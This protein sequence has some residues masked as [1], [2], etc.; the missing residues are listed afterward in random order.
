M[1]QHGRKQIEKTRDFKSLRNFGTF[2]V[3][4]NIII[5]SRVLVTTDGVWIGFTAPYTF[6][7]F[8]S[9]GSTA[10]SLFYPLSVHRYALGFSAYFHE[11]LLGNSSIQWLFLCNV[12]T[13][14]FLVTNLSNGDSSASVAHSLTIYRGTLNC[15]VPPIVFNIT[16]PHGPRRK[17]VPTL[18]ACLPHHCIATVA[19]RT[20]QKT[21]SLL[22]KRV[23]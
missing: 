7:H 10:L 13:R 3:N 12:C 6:T 22:L 4:E 8:E 18:E 1:R 9:T 15:P 17:Q 2:C 14:R 23:N 20:A 21:V 16:P 11:S 19:A 5:L